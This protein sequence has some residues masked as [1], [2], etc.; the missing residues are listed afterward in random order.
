MTLPSVHA[1]ILIHGI[2]LVGIIIVGYG[3][4]PFVHAE[5]RVNGSHAHCSL[6]LGQGSLV[7][8]DFEGVESN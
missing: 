5:T 1:L 6:A 7:S 8:Y 3:T 4:T 2:L